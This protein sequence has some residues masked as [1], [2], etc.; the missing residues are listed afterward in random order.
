MKKLSEIQ[1]D[2]INLALPIGLVIADAGPRLPILC[3]NDL[4][5]QMLGFSSQEELLVANDS[6]AWAFVSPL[7]KRRLEAYATTR[8]GT[9]EAYEITYRAIR[10]DGSLIWVNQ[11]SRHTRDE[12]GRE[13]VFAYCTDITAQKQMEETIRA[14]VEKYETLVNSVPGGVGMYQ[15]DERVTPIFMSDRAYELCSMTKEEYR[16]ATRNSTMDIFHP[17]DRQGFWDVVA[18]AR[19]AN[20]KFEYSHR[21]LQK[22]GSY[23]WMRV[24]GQ[25]LERGDGT[26][27]MYTVFTDIHEQIQAEHALRESET[28][29]A[30]AI[31]SAN[32]NIW[33]YDYATETMTIFSKSPKV[34]PKNNIITDY[35]KTA[36]EGGHIS[37][38][39]ALLLL[40]MIQKL[41][42]GEEEVTADLWIRQNP[43]DDFWCERVIYTNV[44]DEAGKPVKAYCVGKDITREKEAEKRYRDELSYREAMQRAT[45][46]SININLTQNTILDYK[47]I[48]PEITAHIAAAGTVQ[49]YFNQVYTELDTQELQRDCAALFSREA[50][51]RQFA[52]GKT[53]LSMELTRKIEGRRYWTMMTIHM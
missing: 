38:E 43:E 21:V 25:V 3:V 24:S 47:S 51:L 26:P 7:D 33:E 45:M 8:V 9:T 50:L 32:I 41:K 12:T 4:F 28:R 17:D 40:D 49:D 46:A 48:F 27:V 20:R 29:Y 1:E 22:D 15:L 31:K 42:N 11:N 30:A 36:I 53:T 5:V 52:N 39:S 44:F 14:G 34:H 2:L 10:K 16:Y 37:E 6:S 35:T 18:E 13:I 23:R 19:A